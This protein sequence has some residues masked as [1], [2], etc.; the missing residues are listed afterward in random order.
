MS[1]PP[2]R[3]LRPAPTIGILGD[4]RVTA[5]NVDLAPFR[6]NAV[7]VALEWYFDRGALI[8]VAGFYKDIK[9]FVQNYT[10]S[11]SSFGAN[12]FG[13]PDSAGIAACGTQV[14]CAV[15][16]P[17]WTFSYPLNTQGGP[18]AGVEIAYQQPFTFLPSPFDSFG[19]VGNYTYVDSRI[20]YLNSAGAVAAVN[21][22]TNLSHVSY[23]AT[24]YYE[25]SLLSA[26]ISAAYRSKY[27][28]VVP[29]RNGSDL[30]G[31]QA[32]L[33]VDASA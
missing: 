27:L 24:L 13:L 2:L 18:L 9:T 26:R 30:E 5:G 21:Q 10:S 17:Q 25:A 8:S 11:V 33:N 31:T 23:N 1:R 22:L 14:G 16:S 6:A 4:H 29:G 7:D 15:N 32:T 3:G 20:S 12:P 19:F 28:T